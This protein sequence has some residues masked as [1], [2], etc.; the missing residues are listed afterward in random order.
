[1]V[2]L[3]AI[4]ILALAADYSPAAA[5]QRDPP[6]LFIINLEGR[7]G[8]KASLAVQPDLF[9]AGFANRT[10]HWHAFPGYE[11]VIP[12]A[13]L[14]PFGNSYRDLI[15]GLA[16]LPSL[17][18]GRDPTQRAVHALSGH[19]PAAAG[20]DDCEALRLTPIKE[21]V[22]RGWESGDA[23]LT[24][25]HLG[26]IEHWDTMCFELIR[27]NRIGEWSG[28]FTELLRTRANIHSKE[29]ALA[30]VGVI[31]NRPLDQLLMAHA[32]RA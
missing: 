30:V 32:R 1:M 21:T 14:L 12:N 8:D 20:S 26:Y 7:D 3:L 13:T 6:K 15:G 24:P 28:P 16:N 2:A 5:V 17:P 4:L 9:L 10:S 29:D 27:A 11:H 18:L 25:E 31:I 23:H 19:D 22:S